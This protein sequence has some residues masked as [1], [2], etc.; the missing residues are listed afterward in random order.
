MSYNNILKGKGEIIIIK[1]PTITKDAW[2]NSVLT[3]VDHLEVQG[4]ARKMN[5]GSNPQYISAK[6]TVHTQMRFYFEFKD[7]QVN[8]VVVY[9]D[10]E[11]RIT[12]VN[13]VMH[14]G[15]IL[16]VDGFAS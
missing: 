2:G 6:E 8:D 13:N 3:L 4:V 16:Q 5:S 9:E 15:R 10:K 1:R 11:Y 14:Y 7:I 12:S